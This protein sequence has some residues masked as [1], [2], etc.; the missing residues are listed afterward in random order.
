V[1][2]GRRAYCCLASAPILQLQGSA[3]TIK[4]ES[5]SFVFKHVHCCWLQGSVQWASL[6][7][8]QGCVEHRCVVSFGGDAGYQLP[9]QQVCWG[10]V[11]VVA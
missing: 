3:K 6:Q 11:V 2:V 4:Y 7:D 10:V 1:A 5:Q 8:T 9:I